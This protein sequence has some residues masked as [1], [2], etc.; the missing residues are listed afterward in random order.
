VKDEVDERSE[1][2]CFS[3]RDRQNCPRFDR[4]Q[5]SFFRSIL[6]RF[7]KSLENIANIDYLSWDDV[8]PS[9]RVTSHV[10][11]RRCFTFIVDSFGWESSSGSSLCNNT[12]CAMNER[13]SCHYIKSSTETIS[14]QQFSSFCC[15]SINLKE[16]RFEICA[17]SSVLSI[18]ASTVLLHNYCF[19]SLNNFSHTLISSQN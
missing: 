2:P 10:S 6:S 16:C 5:S 13:L 1:D 8:I 11:R 17:G 19:P 12:P 18:S 14:Q 9:C 7:S 15:L 3:A 4:F